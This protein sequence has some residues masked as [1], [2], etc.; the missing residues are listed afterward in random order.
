MAN[1][2]AAEHRARLIREMSRDLQRAK[3]SSK[4]SRAS[5]AKSDWTGSDFAPRNDGRMASVHSA[6]FSDQLPALHGKP[7]NVLPAMEQDK[8]LDFAIDTSAIQ[9]AFPDFSQGPAS[10][11]DVSISIELGRGYKS[12]N[13]SSAPKYQERLSH[14][15]SSIDFSPAVA[16]HFTPNKARH[17]QDKVTKL[18]EEHNVHNNRFDRDKK[19][20][21]A[22]SGMSFKTTN[23]GSTGSRQSSA[24][25]RQNLASVHT[26]VSEY[27]GSQASDERP[28]TLNLTN[29]SSRFASRNVPSGS[30]GKLPS[31]FGTS[32]TFLDDLK[33]KSSTKAQSAIRGTTNNQGTQQSFL[34]PDMPNITELVSGVFEDGTPVFS[35]TSK[36]RPSR[37]I[38]GPKKRSPLVHAPVESIA[39]PEEEQ[40]IFVSLKLLQEKI[41][42]LEQHRSEAEATI[43]E[44]QEKNRQLEQEKQ[45]KR[46]ARRSDSALASSGSDAGDDMGGT[47]RNV[48]E[49]ARLESTVRTLQD[50]L[51]THERRSAMDEITIKNLSRERDAAVSQLGVAYLTTEQLKA[52]NQ[53][54]HEENETLRNE[55]KRLQAGAGKEFATRQEENKSTTTSDVR[56]AMDDQCQI[57]DV[58]QN[59]KPTGTTHGCSVKAADEVAKKPKKTR[60]VIEEYSD[61]EVGEDPTQQTRT[62]QTR[63]KDTT[64]TAAINKDVEQIAQ[65]VTFLSFLDPEKIA[66]LRRELEQERQERKRYGASKD[67]E[68]LHRLFKSNSQP[69]LPRKSSMK[70]V[71]DETRNLADT[72]NGSKRDFVSFFTPSFC[73]FN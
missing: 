3:T 67:D 27:A 54:L 65:D 29:R 6:T 30:A 19:D 50:Q 64:A 31:T 12:K 44:L 63:A 57:L 1:S 71:R 28:V 45:E 33:K 58:N 25:E 16:K 22:V 41:A 72:T 20:N 61:S 21:R 66:N 17:Q 11:T 9:R 49:K 35:L 56:K 52:E 59:L 8:E 47:R 34:L 24:G 39:I 23:Y 46:R 10:P 40:A 43:Q 4:S 69:K 18:E 26:R 62:K 2:P 5:S 36:S 15:G 42:D 70:S 7:D 73:A 32:K 53:S 51:T 37:F 55:V 13:T 48:I 38:P 60:M 14:M 68:V